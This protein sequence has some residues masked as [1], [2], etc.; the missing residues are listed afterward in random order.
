MA[1]G[2][3]LPAGA[4]DLAA[5]RELARREIA[6]LPAATRSLE[7]TLDPYPVEISPALL[8]YQRQVSADFLD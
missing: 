5:S 1:G 6:R 7:P 4:C 2:R 8:E 3:R